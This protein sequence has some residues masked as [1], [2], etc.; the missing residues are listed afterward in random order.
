MIA[1]SETKIYTPEE[2]LELEIVCE[3]RNEY[4][5]G[6][7]IPMTGGTPDHNEIAGN[8]NAS[9][10]LALKGQPYRIFI[11]DQRL[12]IPTIN[13]YTYP[14]VMVLQKPIELQIGRKDTVINP[15]LI[16]EILSKST[17]NYDRSEKFA[18]YRTIPTFKEYLLVDQYRIHVEHYVKTGV[19]Q[20]T[21]SE[22]DDPNITLSLNTLELQIL[23]ADLYE[24]IDFINS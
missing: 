9:L 20:W 1:Q 23:I 5:N 12:W 22:Y 16:A 3:T 13:I 17:Q 2:Y 11:A 4:R 7:I 14:D 8:L 15:V 19:N 10:K 21:F 6:E 24:N 18:T